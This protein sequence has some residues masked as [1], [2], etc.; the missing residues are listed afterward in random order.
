MRDRIIE[1]EF[2]VVGEAEWRVPR[3]GFEQVAYVAGRLSR[4][5]IR[6][7]MFWWWM[8]AITLV[9]LTEGFW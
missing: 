8:F 6:Q 4:W 7:P 9:G 3:S 2:R 5:L 1:G